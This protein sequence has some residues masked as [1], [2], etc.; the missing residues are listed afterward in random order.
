M[1]AIEQLLVE[2]GEEAV[3]LRLPEQLRNMADIIDVRGAYTIAA[4]FGGT[5]IRFSRYGAH[6][7]EIEA[8]IGAENASRLHAIFGG[9][10]VSIPRAF[11]L[12]RFLKHCEIMRRWKSG[13]RAGQLARC[14]NLTERQIYNI[15][16]ANRDDRRDER[17]R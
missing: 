3:R 15:I 9:E 6:R 11:R 10:E 5:R 2:E 4:R 17:S 7:A 12:I 16:A 13:D 14:F 8:L 1:D